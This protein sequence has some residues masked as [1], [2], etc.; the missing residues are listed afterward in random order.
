VKKLILVIYCLFLI[1]GTSYIVRH[2]WG[3]HA[4]KTK[5]EFNRENLYV[6]KTPIN[7]MDFNLF[8][9]SNSNKD[10]M[11]IIFDLNRDCPLCLYEALDWGIAAKTNKMKLNV[12]G[13]TFEK[14]VNKLND[15]C[16]EYNLTF[17]IFNNKKMFDKITSYLN[18]NKLISMTPLKLYINSEKYLFAFETGTHDLNSQ[19][20]FP[21]RVQ[22]IFHLETSNIN[23]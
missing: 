12:I 14:N 4:Q 6:L 8:S 2:F 17:P 1:L 5:W 15:F 23:P 16:K 3:T 13:L 7:F 22:K 21:K 19:K 9:E 18:Q 10:V 11:I 20:E